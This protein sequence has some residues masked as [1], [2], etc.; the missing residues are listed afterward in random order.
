MLSKFL[1]WDFIQRHSSV[2][3]T[4]QL[5]T[6]VFLSSDPY[7]EK[8]IM[9]QLPKKDL[10]FS[11]YSGANFTLEF[12]EEHF[13]NLSFFST[14]ENL[15]IMN[16]EAVSADVFEYFR[17]KITVDDRFVLFFFTKSNK[18]FSEL[19]KNE[20]IT[21]YEIE[22]PRPWDGP[23]IWNLVS[24]V[25]KIKS[26]TS[27]SNFALE[28]LEHN[29]ESFFWLADSILTHFPSGDIQLPLL[30]ELI[31]R[32][33]WDYFEMINLFH[34]N[35]KLLI[36]EML[37]KELDYDWVRE[38]SSK[39]QLHIVKLLFPQEIAQKQKKLSKYDQQI[40]SMSEKLNH[41][42]LR[43]YLDFFGNLEVSAK[44]SD[45]LILNYL[46]MELLR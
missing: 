37:K 12:V 3:N 46:R 29:F 6:Y 24:K 33:R 31:K 4:D 21:A 25:K 7:V 39:V 8:I 28:N 27:L 44:S 42:M 11:I 30:R 1:P 19:V 17:S 43:H 16:A 14:Q 45:P 18:A 9:D 13:V 36:A 15:I 32:E 38:L 22:A 35:P 5:G 41:Q 40:L 26:D 34:K 10:E 2:I 23:M 20:M